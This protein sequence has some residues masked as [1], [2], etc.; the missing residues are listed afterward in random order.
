MSF[1][2]YFYNKGL[3]FILANLSERSFLKWNHLTP[4]KF[5]W[6]SFR[7]CPFRLEYWQYLYHQAPVHLTAQLRE[8]CMSISV[9]CVKIHVIH[10]YSKIYSPATGLPSRKTSIMISL[11]WYY[12]ESLAVP[13]YEPNSSWYFAYSSPMMKMLYLAYT[14]TPFQSS[15]STRKE[16]GR[17]A[18][19]LWI[20]SFPSQNSPDAWPKP[21]L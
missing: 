8:L 12:N 11:L 4:W 14:L 10:L 2:Y 3:I 6:F 9:F 18:V 20:L 13:E 5:F 7:Y 1:W 15:I 17:E 21:A 19:S 16:P